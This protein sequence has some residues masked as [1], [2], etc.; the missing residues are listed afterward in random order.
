MYALCHTGGTHKAKVSAKPCSRRV[1]MDPPQH[2]VG[3]CSGRQNVWLKQIKFDLSLWWHTA[4]FQ[5]P[6]RAVEEKNAYLSCLKGIFEGKSR[7]SISQTIRKFLRSLSRKCSPLFCWACMIHLSTVD[8][9]NDT[10]PQHRVGGV[11]EAKMF[12]LS[13]GNM[14]TA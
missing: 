11:P 14:I 12:D 9:H 3:G 6:D 8:I 7:C 4:K 10:P 1:L 5:R 13:F 2:R